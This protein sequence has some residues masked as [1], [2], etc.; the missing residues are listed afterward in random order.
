MSLVIGTLFDML[1]YDME[2][3]I[4]LIPLVCTYIYLF[5]QSLK[6]VSAYMPPLTLIMLIVG[7]VAQSHFISE[8]C[9]IHDYPASYV[10]KGVIA[11]TGLLFIITYP[12]GRKQSKA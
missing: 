9:M 2:R 8:W 4:P 1:G 10:F 12:F 5:N 6:R 11:S 7:S 3:L